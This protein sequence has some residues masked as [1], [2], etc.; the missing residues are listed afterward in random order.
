MKNENQGK[1]NDQREFALFMFSGIMLSLIVL[2]LIYLI[3]FG[4]EF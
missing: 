1:T 2:G 3:K 4:F